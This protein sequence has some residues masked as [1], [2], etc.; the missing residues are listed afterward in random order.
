VR[1]P[2]SFAPRGGARLALR[3]GQASLTGSL[4]KSRAKAS[5]K[6]VV[7]TVVAAILKGDLMRKIFLLASA[8]AFTVVCGAVW[9]KLGAKHAILANPFLFRRWNCI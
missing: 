6:F 7:E 2:G 1:S 8:I 5:L 4:H 9:W 3:L